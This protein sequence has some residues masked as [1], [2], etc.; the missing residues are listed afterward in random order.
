M[1]KP[2]L[3]LPGRLKACEVIAV[4]RISKTAFF[5]GIKTGRYP[6]ADTREGRI[7]YWYAQTIRPFVGLPADFPA[8]GVQ[9]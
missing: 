9:E 8:A 3:R 6:A 4:L 5:E 1:D 7:P 2:D